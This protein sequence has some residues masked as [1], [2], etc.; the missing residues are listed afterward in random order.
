KVRSLDCGDTA[1]DVDF[2]W[3]CGDLDAIDC[4]TTGDTSFDM[5]CPLQMTVEEEDIN[6][7]YTIG[8]PFV[9][10]ITVTNGNDTPITL[11]DLIIGFPAD[12]YYHGVEGSIPLTPIELNATNPRTV[13]ISAADL[14]GTLA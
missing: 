8:E 1:L 7:T 13:M 10:R 11:D 12:F 6:A 2:A 5:F 4:E 3:G 9:H 14:G